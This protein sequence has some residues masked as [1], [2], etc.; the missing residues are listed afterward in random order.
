M[1]SAVLQITGDGGY[2][3][4]PKHH[5]PSSPKI[6]NFNFS[7]NCKGAGGVRNLGMIKIEFYVVSLKK[8][9]GLSKPKFN[10]GKS[11]FSHQYF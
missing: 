7:E 9:Y 3:Y 6:L 11:D 1:L 5:T 4:T 8:I 2:T 10:F